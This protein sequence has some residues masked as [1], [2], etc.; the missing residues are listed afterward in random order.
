MMLLSNQAFFLPNSPTHAV[1]LLH[2]LGG[3]PYELQMLGEHLHAQGLSVSAIHYPGH[4]KP[5]R[6]MPASTWPQWYEHAE[7]ELMALRRRFAHVDVIGFSTGCLIALHLAARHPIDRIALLSPFLA[8]KREWYFLLPPEL[9]L[10]GFV[11]FL[12]EVPRRS[13]PLK[14]R[15]LCAEMERVAYFKTFNLD[16]TRSALDLIAIVRAELHEIKAPTLIL[17][18]RRDSVVSPAGAAALATGLTA[19]PVELVWYEK[20][21]HALALDGEREHVF[22]RVAAFISHPKRQEQSP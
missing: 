11:R 22:A 12:G 15:T 2:G 10:K 21:D 4:D 7:Q 9:Y 16:A 3:G 8:I 6:R 1:L 5:Q 13:P 18:S 17:Q 14:D 20:S 19:A